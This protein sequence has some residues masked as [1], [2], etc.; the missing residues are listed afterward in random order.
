MPT[1]GTE[2]RRQISIDDIYDIR[3]SI[4][5]LTGKVEEVAKESTATRMELT[6]GL[7][8]AKAALAETKSE[9]LLKMSDQRRETDSTTLKANIIWAAFSILGTSLITS[10]MAYY[11]TQIVG[12][13]KP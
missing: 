2:R 8:N 13:H 3:N 9:L 7:A 11:F 10:A 4:E 6:N 12:Q 5:R 1:S